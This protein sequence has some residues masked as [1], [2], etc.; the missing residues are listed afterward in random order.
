MIE[1]NIFDKNNNHIKKLN[2]SE[3]EAY[4]KRFKRKKSILD[5]MLDNDI[6]AKYGC[7]GGSCSACITEVLEGREHI[8]N[9]GLTKQV[10]KGLNENDI[11]TCISTLIFETNENRNNKQI[12]LRLKL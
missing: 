10:Y 4:N 5:I 12:K 7:M 1:I 2:I 9:E 11:L 6:N 8:N 3:E